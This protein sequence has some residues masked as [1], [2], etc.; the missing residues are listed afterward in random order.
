MAK[1]RIGYGTD[2]SLEN[3][4]VGIRT[5]TPTKYNL[6]LRGSNSTLL[7]DY[8]NVGVATIGSFSGFLDNLVQFLPIFGSYLGILDNF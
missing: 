4:L 8:Y 1:V 5:D 7:K 2:F 3:E 6:D